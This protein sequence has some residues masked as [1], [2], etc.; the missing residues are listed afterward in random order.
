MVKLT[1]LDGRP[2]WANL[3]HMLTATEVDIEGKTK[4]VF[5]SGTSITVKEKPDEVMAK[6]ERAVAMSI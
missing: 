2:I 4:I 6:A 5:S 3:D 1:L